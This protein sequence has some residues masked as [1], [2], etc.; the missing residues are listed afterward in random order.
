MR[1]YYEILG[2]SKYASEDDIKKAFR[3]LAHQYHPDKL[4]GD[5]K[6]FKEVNEAYQVLS[7]KEKRAQYDQFGRTFSGAEGGQHGPFGFGQQGIGGFGF[8][9]IFSGGGFG[10]EDLQAKISA[11]YSAIFSAEACARVAGASEGWISRPTSASRL[12]KRTR[13]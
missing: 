13:A 9:D 12:K 3:R 5:E 1:D 6:K 7:N 11:T 2:V 4:G 8:S 10:G